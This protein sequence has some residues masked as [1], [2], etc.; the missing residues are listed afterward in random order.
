M[1]IVK[2]VVSWDI[3]PLA[4]FLNPVVLFCWG[5]FKCK[6]QGCYL[7]SNK[8]YSHTRI[9]NIIQICLSL[10][11]LFVK[12]SAPTIFFFFLVCLFVWLL[13][14]LFVCLL[15][16]RIC[17]VTSVRLWECFHHISSQSVLDFISSQKE[18]SLLLELSPNMDFSLS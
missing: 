16:L 10:T 7:R 4:M 14:C 8:N 3:S 15:W 12:L 6:S 18:Y 13:I 11:C 5:L 2:E 1:I 9:L 17:G